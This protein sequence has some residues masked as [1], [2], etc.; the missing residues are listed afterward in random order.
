MK[1]E[2]NTIVVTGGRERWSEIRTK[3]ERSF[4]ARNLKMITY[5]LDLYPA[6]FGLGPPGNLLLLLLY[7]LRRRRRPPRRRRSSSSSSASPSR[8]AR[9]RSVVLYFY[10]AVSVRTLARSLRSRAFSRPRDAARF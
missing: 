6:P 10:Y 7:L 9:R 1:N 4:R 5:L 2:R 8:S 3:T